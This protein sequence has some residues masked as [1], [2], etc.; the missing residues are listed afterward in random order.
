MTW[1]H[2]G[3]HCTSVSDAEYT[4]WY[5]LTTKL[6][7][8]H[9]ILLYHVNDQQHLDSTKRNPLNIKLPAACVCVSGSWTWQTCACRGAKTGTVAMVIRVAHPRLRWRSGPACEPHTGGPR[10]PPAC[11]PA[12]RE[13]R[14]RGN[15]SWTYAAPRHSWSAPR[16]PGN[17]NNTRTHAHTHTHTA[18]VQDKKWNLTNQSISPTAAYM[19]VHMIDDGAVT[20]NSSSNLGGQLNVT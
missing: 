13:R 20:G 18:E 9:T 19:F 11:G 1:D 15:P 12:S 17:N 4:R 2:N 5:P 8:N 16:L 3:L 10:P 6:E 7:V 14:C